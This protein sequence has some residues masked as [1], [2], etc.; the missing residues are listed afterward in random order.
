[1]HTRNQNWRCILGGKVK[2]RL[3]KKGLV[4]LIILLAC[5]LV[6]SGCG[7]KTSTS[8]TSQATTNT[9]TST[10]TK[11]AV[12]TTSQTA[13]ITS[14]AASPTAN[15]TAGTSTA[16]ATAS[17][18][19]STT[20]K[21]GGTV[22]RAIVGSPINLGH[23][24]KR[25][26]PGDMYMASPAIES[27]IDSSFGNYVPRLAESYEIATDGKSITF[28]LRKNVKF[29][30]GTPF[31]ADAVKV[32]FDLVRTLGE[33]TSMK[34]VTSVD[35][36]DEFTVRLVLTQFDWS[37]MSTMATTSAGRI[38]SPKALKENTPE[39]LL[40]K[41]IGTGPF[42]FV[43]YQKDT[44]IKYVRFDD[45]WQKGRPYLDAVDFKI[46]A[47][48]TTATMA[49]KAGEVNLMLVSAE[50]MLTLKKSGFNI[51]E[52][53]GKNAILF[54]D[55]ANKDSPFAD[56]RVRKAVSYAIDRKLLAKSLGY[57][58]YYPTFQLYGDWS[59]LAYNANI[60][61][62]PYDPAKAKQLL[63][64]AGYP[65]GFKTSI[66]IGTS[67]SDLQIAIQ[68]M[69]AAVN[70]Q[71]EIQEITTTKYSDL[72][73]N[74]WKNGMLNAVSPIGEGH[75][76]PSQNISSNYLSGVGTISV[77]YP[78]DLKTLFQQSK[79]E[80]D[81]VKRKVILQEVMK[82]IVDDYC[83]VMHLYITT[84]FYA[85]SPDVH[86]PEVKSFYNVMGKM[87]DVWRSK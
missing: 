77:Y 41:P 39:Q 16:V 80:M 63:T 8:A 30:D 31:N 20:P 17:P 32:N 3:S 24:A 59:P 75:Q 38:Y 87:E 55:G 9:A 1:M 85:V 74:G 81:P 23:P 35:V 10:S 48:S 2:V 57:G 19:A 60:V 76:D 61:G 54:P 27:L 79:T 66:Y 46:F 78:D 69:L 5:M 40:F 51:V 82:K 21:Y 22:V 34:S 15:Q 13:T 64:E 47:D 71:A 33:L 7:T 26:G 12:T 52:F 70:I 29:H 36:V 83:I 4:P 6:M 65:N 44:L 86:I 11:P 25:G 45:Y 84:S 18:T 68:D 42:K 28:H 49:M 73:F 67:A 72:S 53:I 62:Q 50:D 56:V 14:Q 43:S 37:L 58:Y